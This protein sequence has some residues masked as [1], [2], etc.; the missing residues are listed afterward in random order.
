MIENLRRPLRRLLLGTVGALVLII[1]SPVGAALADPTKP[2][3]PSGPKGPGGSD[4]AGP[5]RC[6]VPSRPQAAVL[7][8]SR[9]PA[10]I[11]QFS[12][13]FADRSIPGG[14]RPAV[15]IRNM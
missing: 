8:R 15:R 7:P 1:A 10:K 6:R 2:H 9:Q 5:S 3:G 13:H 11:L 12:F 14:F 4:V